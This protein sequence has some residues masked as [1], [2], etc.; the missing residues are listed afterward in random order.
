MWAHPFLTVQ[1]T[2]KPR[3]VGA[4]LDLP[5][6]GQLPMLRYLGPEAAIVAKCTSHCFYYHLI[7]CF[8]VFA[9]FSADGHGPTCEFCCICCSSPA[10]IWCLDHHA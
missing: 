10:L 8:G 6:P 7:T 2:W 1:A 5:Q 3:H 4:G 9:S